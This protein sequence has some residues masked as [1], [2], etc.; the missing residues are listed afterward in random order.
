MGQS[1]SSD[2]WKLQIKKELGLYTGSFLRKMLTMGESIPLGVVPVEGKRSIKAL[3]DR[4]QTP[5]PTGTS[6]GPLQLGKEE[7]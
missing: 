1:E 4:Q 2:P 3:G 6:G 7:R 5:V